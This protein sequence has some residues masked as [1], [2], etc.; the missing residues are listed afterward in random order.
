VPPSEIAKPQSACVEC[1]FGEAEEVLI[2][3]AMEGGVLYGVGFGSANLLKMS[4]VTAAAML[5]ICLLA[6]VETMTTA[7]AEDPRQ[8]NGKIAFTHTVSYKTGDYSD[9]YTVNPDGTGLTN[10]TSET[11]AGVSES[12]PAFSPDGT[13]LAFSIDSNESDLDSSDI[14]VMNAAGSKPRRLTNNDDYRFQGVGSWSPDGARMV[15]DCYRTGG[16]VCTMD[17]DGSNHTQLTTGGDNVDPDWSPDGTKIAFRPASGGDIY[18]MNPD[19]SNPTLA[20]AGG[21]QPDWSPDGT[22][23]AYRRYPPGQSHSDIF[24]ANA[25][26]SNPVD[27]TAR[28]GGR[29]AD[30][31]KPYE[32]VPAWSPD[33]T[34][35]AF[36]SNRGEKIE[37]D[38]EIYVLDANGRNLK[39]LTHTPGTNWGPDWQPVSKP[40][41]ATPEKQRQERQQNQQQLPQQGSKSPSV[42]VQ[43]PDTGGLSLL[44]AASA[45]LFAGS[46]MFYAAVKRSL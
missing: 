34:K 43:P 22:K 1:L 9:I 17:A 32:A 29:S 15:L 26:G 8:Y 25:D 44:W 37:T 10:L 12:S 35:I 18:T 11:S 41:E 33:G 21:D 36:S 31:N 39:R 3:E 13:K 2:S 38:Y 28:I 30:G 14:Y 7:E 45:L 46:V 20:I 40:T 16:E 24:V 23:I 4:L 5:A 19:G 42:T 6:L 27:L